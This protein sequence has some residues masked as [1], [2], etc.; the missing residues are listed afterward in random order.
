MTTPLFGGLVEGPE[1]SRD[2]G[3]SGAACSTSIYIPQRDQTKHCQDAVDDIWLVVLTIVNGKDD[4]PYMKWK[5]K[6][7][8]ETTNQIF[9]A[10]DCQFFQLVN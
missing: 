6:F 5:I 1:K 8:F 4:I 7:M 9:T 3:G 10:L 2:I